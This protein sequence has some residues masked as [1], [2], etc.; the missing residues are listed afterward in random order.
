MTP[1]ALWATTAQ[2]AVTIDWVTVGN[3]GNDPDTRY[4]ATGFGSVADTYRISKYEVINGQYIDFL[5]AVAAV[6]DANGLYNTGMAGTYG[7]IDRAGSG[8]GGD[9][10]VYSA[11]GADS[12]WLVRPV[13][14]VS[15][16][17]AV[18]FINW[19]ENGQP[20]TGGQTDST[21]EDGT[22]DM[23]GAL[24]RKPGA[25][26]F[27]P[28]EDEWYKAAYHKND[29]VTG[30]Y[31]DYPTGSNTAPTAES[32]PGT[33]MTNGSANYNSVVGS[34]YYTTP[35]GAYSAKPSTTPYGT[36]DQGGNVWEWNE[37][38]VAGSS[39]G[40]RG[41]PFARSPYLRASYRLWFVPSFET[42]SFGFRVASP[43]EPFMIPEP[44]AFLIWTLL[45][46][47][48]IAAACRRR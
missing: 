5:N 20:A 17:D 22:Y 7:G 18:R 3:P 23:D 44:S 6:G 27:L 15:W 40:V 46:G 48:G 47:L 11:R 9:P 45:A 35:V 16:Y 32:P 38:L 41:G 34:P 1:L 13:N 29:G 42:Y 37:T 43:P 4:D 12:N 33:D 36:F 14:Y 30:N 19:L 8:T 10:W 31:W 25:A 21:T 2:A 28:T 26:L 24:T 39:R